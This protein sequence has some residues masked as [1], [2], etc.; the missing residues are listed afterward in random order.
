M[1]SQFS[2][3]QC[4]FIFYYLPSSCPSA[5]PEYEGRGA[6][7]LNIKLASVI[8]QL[9][10]S[11]DFINLS[12]LCLIPKRQCWILYIDALV[13]DSGGN[14]FDAISLA[15]RAALYNTMLPKVKVIETTRR[16]EYELELS[17][18]YEDCI[19][20]SVEKVPIF[21]SFNQI[22]KFFIVDPSTEEELCMGCRITIGINNNGN[23]CAIDQGS[24][25]IK[26]SIL[27]EITMVAK[28]I[29]TK[30]IKDMDDYL[31]KC[32]PKPN[33]FFL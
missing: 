28:N 19:R 8:E 4:L 14:L 12:S 31:A 15:T 17:D 25:A 9:M 1:N 23:I 21:I 18:D 26:P 22:G 2:H 29:G 10:L 33:Q 13:M 11:S 27:P 20:I 5:S 7:D 3:P 24:G 30:M 6:D 32:E 16:G